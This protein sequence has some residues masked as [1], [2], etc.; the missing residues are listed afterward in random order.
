PQTPRYP[1]GWGGDLTFEEITERLSPMMAN[2]LR[3]FGNY[4]QDI[5]DSIQTGLMRLWMRLIEDPNLLAD[6]GIFGAMWR[7]LAISKSTTLQK[8][9]KKYLPFTDIEGE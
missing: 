7:A 9:N 6:V 4:G 8:Q 1:T 5:P 2:K 3:R